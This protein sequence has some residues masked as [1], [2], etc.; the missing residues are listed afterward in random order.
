MLF[1]SRASE[2]ARELNRFLEKERTDR[3]IAKIQNP[4]LTKT[5][6][7]N[8]D[9]T[10]NKAGFGSKQIS[11]ALAGLLAIAVTLWFSLK[12]SAPKP[13]PTPAL[14]PILQASETIVAPV[15]KK[16]AEKMAA[17]I[18]HA[19]EP[20][21]SK[22]EAPDKKAIAAAKLAAKLAAKSKAAL[23]TE[24]IEPAPVTLGIVQIAVAPWGEVYVDGQNKGITPPLTKLNLPVG[25]HK[26]EIKNGDDSYA[27]TVEVNTEKEVKIAHRF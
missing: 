2:M 5:S 17:P 22:I 7:A 20:I 24:K 10:I 27:V 9:V 21:I 25:K 13:N 12:P 18:A 6:S 16:Q 4:A 1:R 15:E 11:Y 3:I 14:P 19:E 8:D 26:I 23:A